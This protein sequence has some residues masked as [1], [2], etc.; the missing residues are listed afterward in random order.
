MHAM[1]RATGIQDAPSCLGA[2]SN[3]VPCRLSRSRPDELSCF[4]ELYPSSLLLLFAYYFSDLQLCSFLLAHTC[5]PNLPN[6][7]QQSLLH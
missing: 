5:R 4:C 1:T 2:V 6:M 7:A 3:L